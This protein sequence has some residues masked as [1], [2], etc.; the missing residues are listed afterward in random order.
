MPDDVTV[1]GTLDTVLTRTGFQV[2]PTVGTIPYPYTFRLSEREVAEVI[3]VPLESVMADSA[4][5]HEARL[6]GDG[7]L[8]T[9]V[10]FAHGP[11]LVYGATATILE[12]L[13]SLVQELVDRGDAT[14]S[15]TGPKEVV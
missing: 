5:R 12:Q 8:Q 9:R 7:S 4:L 10:A 14:L 15:P 3:E 11:H 1:L 6:L 2:W 13:L